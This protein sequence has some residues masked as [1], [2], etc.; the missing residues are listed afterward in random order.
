V[1][2][3]VRG[4][5]RIAPEKEGMVHFAGMV[6]LLALMALITYFDVQRLLEGSRLLP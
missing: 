6:V 3:L 2:E 5:R 4:G 1:I